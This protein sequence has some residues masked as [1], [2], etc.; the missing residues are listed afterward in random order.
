M[1]VASGVRAFYDWATSAGPG[2]VA[3]VIAALIGA[4]ALLINGWRQRK[5]DSLAAVTHASNENR[6]AARQRLDPA[7]RALIQITG[8]LEVLASRLSN[9]PDQGVQ[10]A[11]QTI[12]DARRRIDLILE[13]ELKGA[14]DELVAINGRLVQWYGIKK[15]LL[16]DAKANRSSNPRLGDKVDDLEV[17]VGTRL[18]AIR[19]VLEAE[20]AQLNR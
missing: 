15:G 9:N 17:E 4:I 8:D 10:E 12:R 14:K 20:V 6:M 18:T 5:H 11:S 2:P 1:N 7:V 19:R 16:E 13:P 3:I